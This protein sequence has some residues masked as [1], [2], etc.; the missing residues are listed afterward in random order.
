MEKLPVFEIQIKK[1]RVIT[2]YNAY[3]IKD[4]L[5]E[6]GFKY[7]SFSKIW[8]KKIVSDSID[9]ILETAKQYFKSFNCKV[10]IIVESDVSTI[11]KL[12]QKY[13]YLD[14]IYNPSSSYIY[15]EFYNINNIDFEEM[16]N[17]LKSNFKISKYYFSAL[18]DLENK[19][20]TENVEKYFLIENK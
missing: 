10:R 15:I 2:V 19:K 7:L 3:P 20:I 9:D 16:Y 8:Q 13:S 1:E 4:T 14:S 11:L 5:K 6:K 17:A 18:E 12:R